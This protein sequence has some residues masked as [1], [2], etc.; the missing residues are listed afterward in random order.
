MACRT[1]ASTLAV[2]GC[3]AGSLRTRRQPPAQPSR[4]ARSRSGSD[5][6]ARR[7]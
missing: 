1:M 5:L 2:G 6:R 7:N 4:A 3:P